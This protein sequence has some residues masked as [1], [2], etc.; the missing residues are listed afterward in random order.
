MNTKL[1]ISFQKYVKDTIGINLEIQ[2]NLNI[3]QL[4]FFISDKYQLIEIT[5]L[6][7]YFIV[8]M[9]K[10][11]VDETPSTLKN[12]IELIRDKLHKEVIFL[13]SDI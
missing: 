12:H 1:I 4:P 9:S 6:G 3:D 13:D 10:A 8:I 7:H 11:K 5:L 2:K